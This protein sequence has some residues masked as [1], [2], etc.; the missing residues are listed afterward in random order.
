[1]AVTPHDEYMIHQTVA[2]VDQL[3]NSD[4]QWTERVWFSAFEK[5]GAFQLVFGLGKYHNR[6]VMDCSIALVA[7]GKVQYNVRAS[8]GLWPDLDRYAVGPIEYSIP[9]PLQSVR[10]TTGANESGFSCDLRFIGETQIYEQDPPM[11]RRRAGRTVNHMLRYFQTG[12]LEGWIELEGRR[13]EVRRADWWAGRDRSWG[14]RSNTAERTSPKG[15][16][17]G[18]ASLVEPPGEGI[19]YR[20]SF[21]SLQFDDWNASFEFAQTPEGH[22]LGPALGHLQHAVHTQR[23][24]QKIVH[25]DHEWDFAPDG[26]RLQGIRSILHLDDSST[27]EVEMEPISIAYRRP[28]GGHYGGYGDWV[29]GA[30]LGDL[31]VEGDKLELTNE[32]VSELHNVED[33]ALRLRHDGQTG[34]GVAEPLIPGIAELL[35]TD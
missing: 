35:T 21:F 27:K 11:F 13:I 22:R 34:W 28:G 4:P 32:L 16:S 25:V 14:L 8:R 12:A 20:W 24:P 6:N 1:M 26:V 7:D 2:T 31:R 19:A 17:V 30:W 33:Y 23:P 15:E 18:S 10:I 3:T 9:E 29:Q 5:S